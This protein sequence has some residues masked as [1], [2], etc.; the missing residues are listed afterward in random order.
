MSAESRT[1]ASRKRTTAFER[2]LLKTAGFFHATGLP[3]K[4][5][6]GREYTIG[7][8]LPDT[9]RG[10]WHHHNGRTVIVTVGGEVWLSLGDH[11]P[12]PDMTQIQSPLPAVIYKLCP[13]LRQPELE[14]RNFELF[15]PLAYGE[16]INPEAVAE[17]IKNPDWQM[18]LV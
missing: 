12:R 14:S 13:N 5:V 2:E 17:R 9:W 6:R 7:E 18:E 16:H 1:P 11:L 8:F 4:N 15:V 3:L 10:S